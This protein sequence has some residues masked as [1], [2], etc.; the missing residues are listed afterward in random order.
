MTSLVALPEP[1]RVSAVLRPGYRRIA[2]LDPCN[3]GQVVWADAI[4]P[5]G[6]LLGYVNADHWAVAL[7]IV[8]GAPPGLRSLAAAPVDRNGFPREVL[9][10]A[11]VR[12]VEEAL[13]GSGQGRRGPLAWLRDR[14]TACRR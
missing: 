13:L 9:L 11:V 8:R 5:G 7:P 10:E 3:D 4:V 6:T 14:I 2:R 1:D 12:Q